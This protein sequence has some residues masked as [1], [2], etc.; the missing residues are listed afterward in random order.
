[1]DELKRNQM[2]DR[3]FIQKELQRKIDDLERQIKE[4]KE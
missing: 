2:N 3:E 4:L 1:M